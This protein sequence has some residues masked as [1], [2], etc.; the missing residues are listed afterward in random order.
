[1]VS[2]FIAW[3]CLEYVGGFSALFEKIRISNPQLLSTPG[4]KGLLSA[5]FLLAT[6][7]VIIAMPITQPQLTTRIIIMKD[8]KKMRQ[9]AIVTAVFSIIVIFPAMI[10]GLYEAV[11]HGKLSTAVF[12]ANALLYD[13]PEAIAA[14]ALV[15]LIAAA[16]STADSHFF[17]LGSE[18]KTLLGDEKEGGLFKTKLIMFGFGFAA[19]F[20]AIWSSDQ[21]VLLAR[22]S[23]SGTALL[24]P[25]VLSVVFS[26]NRPSIF[27]PI[28][29]VVALVCFSLSLVNVIPGEIGDYG[30]DLSL[31]VI[32]FVC[33]FICK[34]IPQ[35]EKNTTSQKQIQKR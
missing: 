25:L 24:A 6:F 18:F 13:Q 20:F 22:V 26:E 19:L 5:Q 29:T 10:T 14:A 33:F 30:L 35:S 17:A 2:W 32:L 7:L 12:L 28:A 27:I 9:M 8:F 3:N 1:M 16:M 15:G 34:F 31:L 23:F 21:L 11:V 4:P